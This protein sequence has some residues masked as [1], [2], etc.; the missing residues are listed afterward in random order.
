MTC[1]SKCATMGKEKLSNTRGKRTLGIG[2]VVF[3]I[4]DR[5]YEVE[6]LSAGAIID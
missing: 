1:Y 2:R 3:S 6:S 4:K 5:N